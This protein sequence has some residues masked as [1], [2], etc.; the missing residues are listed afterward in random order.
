MSLQSCCKAQAVGEVL[1]CGRENKKKQLLLAFARYNV[2]HLYV[3]FIIFLFK[4]AQ[5]CETKML[6]YTG[7]S[8]V[9]FLWASVSVFLSVVS[10]FAPAG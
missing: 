3:S 10:L 2:K 9:S 8:N 4:P 7:G 6:G 5:F 1:T